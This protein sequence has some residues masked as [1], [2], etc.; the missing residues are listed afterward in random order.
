M[1]AHG[2][3]FGVSSSLL[4]PTGLCVVAGGSDRTRFGDMR[5][6]DEE[7]MGNNIVDPDIFRYKIEV[8]GTGIEEYYEYEVERSCDAVR[9]EWLDDVEGSWGSAFRTAFDGA[10]SVTKLWETQNKSSTSERSAIP[11]PPVP[12]EELEE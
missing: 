5:L 11:M 9:G 12:Q 7:T 3:G 2:L 4:A 6:C 10:V 8:E 1:I